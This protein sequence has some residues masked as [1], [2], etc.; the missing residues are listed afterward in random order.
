MGV[1]LVRHGPTDLN[2]GNGKQDEALRGWLDV[3]LNA[4]GRED[5]AKAAAH[6]NENS[7]DGLYSSDLSRAHDTAKAIHK[8]TKLPISVDSAFRP[9]D[10][11]DMAG[12]KIKEILPQMHHLI[13]HPDEPAPGGESFND[14]LE[15]YTPAIKPLV[16]AKGNYIVVAHARNAM[17][18]EGMAKNKG[19]SIDPATLKTESSVHPAGYI[20]VNPD[21]SYTIHNIEDAKPTG[22]GS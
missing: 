10:A 1:I 13:D 11:G 6:F 4:R 22:A 3:P 7:A 12:K 5:A 18:L 15:R 20:K 17:V 16:E 19:E 21:W 14:F 9:W 2:A 8:T